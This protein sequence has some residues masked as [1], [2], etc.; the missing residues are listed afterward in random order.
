MSDLLDLL[1]PSSVI[2]TDDAGETFGKRLFKSL[3]MEKKVEPITAKGWLRGSAIGD[4]CAREE[5]LVHRLQKTRIREE[6]GGGAMVYGIGSNFHSWVQKNAHPFLVGT[7]KCMNRIRMPDWPKGAYRFCGY[8]TDSDEHPRVPLPKT[9]C[10]RCL[11]EDKWKYIERMYVNREYRVRGHPDGFRRIT[12]DPDDDEI[13]E[14]KTQA[15][16]GWKTKVE[17]FAAYMKQVQVYLWLTGLKR[18]R[19]VLVNKNGGGDSPNG[20]FKEHVYGRDENEI[21]MIKRNAR[22]V[23]NG[24]SENKLPER[25]CSTRSCKRAENCQLMNHCFATNEGVV[26]GHAAEF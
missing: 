7:W 6:S 17:P 21:E 23:W 20:W 3:K 1:N 5:V 26:Y 13:L 2:M 12:D 19:I 24:I 11:G 4:M 10:P 25:V 15:E 8:R 18:A 9:A 16:W 14:F 22:N